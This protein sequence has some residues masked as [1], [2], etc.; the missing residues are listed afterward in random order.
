ML[1]LVRCCVDTDAQVA[2]DGTYGRE[3]WFCSHFY[4]GKAVAA[5]LPALCA[6]V[7]VRPPVV[8]PKPHTRGRF[9]ARKRSKDNQFLEAFEIAEHLER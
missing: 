1:A 7:R 4:V 2:S 8:E 9:Y 3:C 5:P 6:C